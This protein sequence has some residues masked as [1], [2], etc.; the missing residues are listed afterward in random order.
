MCQ[1]S[2]DDP[3]SAIS[4]STVGKTAAGIYTGDESAGATEDAGSTA[5][6]V[7]AGNVAQYKK[8]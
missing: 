6:A 5:M 2:A 7:S 4:I 8:H 3:G 1:L